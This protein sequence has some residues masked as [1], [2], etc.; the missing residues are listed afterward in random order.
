MNYK[1]VKERM[2]RKEESVKKLIEF[3]GREYSYSEIM[4]LMAIAQTTI[5]ELADIASLHNYKKGMEEVTEFF[6]AIQ[7]LMIH[8]E[9]LSD[10]A[11]MEKEDE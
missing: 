4:T 7:C 11:K 8:L 5:M 3:L 6:V 10:F 9:N 1:Q 2:E